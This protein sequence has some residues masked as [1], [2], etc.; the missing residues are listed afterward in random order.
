M[1]CVWGGLLKSGWV[2]DGEWGG[3]CPRLF[4]FFFFCTENIDGLGFG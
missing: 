1:V 3:D 4:F 2:I